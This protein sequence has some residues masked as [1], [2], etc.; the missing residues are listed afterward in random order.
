M[1]LGKTG[2]SNS[3]HLLDHLHDSER[4]RDSEEQMDVIAF[5]TDRDYRAVNLIEYAA[6]VRV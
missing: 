1:W 6:E 4:T 5:T 2:Y 3:F